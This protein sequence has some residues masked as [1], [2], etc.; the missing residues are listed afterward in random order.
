MQADPR[1]L[2][3]LGKSPVPLIPY[4]LFKSCTKEFNKYD[5]CLKKNDN[6]SKCREEDKKSSNC[7]SGYMR[8]V[9]AD[10]VNT[11]DRSTT[12]ESG[13]FKEDFLNNFDSCLNRVSDKDNGNTSEYNLQFFQYNLSFK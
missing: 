10:C 8:N 11:V 9:M 4:Y 1:Q 6:P 5:S 3:L 12:D 2:E 13:K 7:F